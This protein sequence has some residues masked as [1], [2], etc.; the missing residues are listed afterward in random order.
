[1]E[2]KNEMVEHEGKRAIL[3]STEQRQ[4]KEDPGESCVDTEASH[5]GD[6]AE[7]QRASADGAP[8]PGTL[9]NSES[10]AKL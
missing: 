8:S 7:D 3:Q 4:H 9:V 5:P 10:E 2:V 1:M 6:S